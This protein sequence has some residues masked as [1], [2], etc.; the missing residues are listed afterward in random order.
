[1]HPT[2]HLHLKHHTLA[3]RV[4]GLLQVALTTSTA[5]LQQGRTQREP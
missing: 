5:G 1:M 3:F 4:F 2:S